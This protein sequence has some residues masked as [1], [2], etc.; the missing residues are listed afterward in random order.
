MSS[1][2]LRLRRTRVDDGAPPRAGADF[3]QLVG[4]QLL[5]SEQLERDTLLFV[6]HLDA[7]KDGAPAQVGP[8]VHERLAL[9]RHFRL[10]EPVTNDLAIDAYVRDGDGGTARAEIDREDATRRAGAHVLTE[11]E[12]PATRCHEVTGVLEEVE[13]ND[14]RG[15]QA[16]QQLRAVRQHAPDL[17]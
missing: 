5:E 13:S 12:Q 1:D 9:L 10:A 6:E 3:S 4:E 17:R 16:M 8:L 11:G 7:A 2:A 14:V 15:E